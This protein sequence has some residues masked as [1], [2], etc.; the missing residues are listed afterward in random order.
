MVQQDR[1]SQVSRCRIRHRVTGSMQALDIEVELPSASKDLPH[2]TAS[3]HP[4][5]DE[6]GDV[7][8]V[9]RVEQ[10]TIAHTV[11]GVVA[12]SISLLDVEQ[13]DRDNSEA[14]L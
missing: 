10:M 1:N 8:A 11:T 12:A 2:N 3:R 7:L 4:I 13:E 5:V 14:S 9:N 6:Q